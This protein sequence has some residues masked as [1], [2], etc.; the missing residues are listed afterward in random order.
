VVIPVKAA[1]ETEIALQSLRQTGQLRLEAGDWAAARDAFEA[2]LRAVPGDPTAQAGIDYSRQRETMDG[3][4]AAALA[5]EEAGDWQGALQALEAIQS[6][7]PT[8]PGIAQRIANLQ[9]RVTIEASWQEAQARVQA[10]DWPGAISALN[11]VRGQDPEFRKAE[12]EDQLYQAYLQLALPQLDGAN[13][14]VDQIRQALEYLDRALALKPTEEQYS[15]ERRLAG[16]FVDGAD[17]MARQ[18][19]EAAVAAWEPVYQARPDYQGGVLRDYMRQAYPQAAAQLIARADGSVSLLKQAIGYLAQAA[20]LD[21]SNSGL[22]DEQRLASE[23]VAGAEAFAEGDWRAAVVHLGP[24]YLVR[25]DYQNGVLRSE[26]REA[27]AKS[28][29]PDPAYCKP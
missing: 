17:A 14:N 24:V 11:A 22:V 19:W 15:E 4:Y 7:D 25:P 8:Y 28:P 2:L 5:A 29:T 16:R 27:C 21:P 6:Q 18:D 20:I 13:G 1:K 12:V 3:Q 23:F 26:L 9:H 10:A